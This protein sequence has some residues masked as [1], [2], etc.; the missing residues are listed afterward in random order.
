MSAKNRTS[1]TF[2]S[3]EAWD[4]GQVVV[5]PHSL[6]LEVSAEQTFSKASRLSMSDWSMARATAGGKLDEGAGLFPFSF[7]VGSMAM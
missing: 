2:L 3:K 1:V 4:V 5:L 7:F 6:K